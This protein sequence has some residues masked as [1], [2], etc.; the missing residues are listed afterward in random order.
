M[1]KIIN[2]ELVYFTGEKEC[3]IDFSGKE[4]ALSPDERIAFL[5]EYQKK[6][7]SW[8]D[9]AN[10]NQKAYSDDEVNSFLSAME[11][12]PETSIRREIRFDKMTAYDVYRE[13]LYNG[14]HLY[15]GASLSGNEITFPTVEKRGTPCAHVDI[16]PKE[17]LTVSLEVYT[18]SEYLSTQRKY[19]G[20]A[21]GGRVIELRVDTVNKAKI[22]I[23]NTGE[24]LALS[25]KMWAPTYTVIGTVEFGKWNKFTIKASDTF[26]VS[27]NDA[28]FV[29]GLASIAEGK[30]DNIFFDGGMWGRSEW[31]VRNITVDG[32]K[33]SYNENVNVNKVSK[34]E[35]REVS[36]PYA[37]G[38]KKMRN[39]ELYLTRKFNVDSFDYAELNIETLD[40]CGKVWINDKLVLDT[41]SFLAEKICI[42]DA[43]KCGENEIKIMVAPRAP[44]TYYFWHRHTDCYNGWFCGAV[45]IS[46]TNE[47]RICDLKVKTKSVNPV[48][49]IAEISSSFD[50]EV[51]LSAFEIFPNKGDS[52][53]LGS[54]KTSN[55]K[56]ILSF[57][58]DKLKLWNTKTP[59]LYAVKAELYEGDKAIDDFIVET[60]FRTICQKD[61]G[62]FLNDEQ[63]MLNGALLMQFLPP[64]DEVPVNHNCPTDFQIAMQM[65]S[66]KNMNGNF[67]RLHMLGYGSNDKRYARICDRLGIM[68]AWTTRLI[69]SLEEMAWDLKWRER[70][71]FVA[72]I[73]DVMNYPSIIMY[74]G[75]NEYHSKDLATVDRMYNDF[76]EAIVEVD[77]TRL[78]SPCSHLYYGGGIYEMG[79]CYFNDTGKLDQDGNPASAGPG[80]TQ[81]NV[82]RSAHT[83]DILCGYGS[84]WEV[85]RK[86]NWKWQDEML[87]SDK[88]AYLITEYA[89]TALPNPTTPEA[90]KT[91]YPQSYER[92]DELGAIDR[93][94]EDD[95]WR[96][97]QA[98]QALCAAQAVKHMRLKGVDGLAWCCLMSGAN[99]G[100]YMKPPIDFY[101]YKKLGFYSLRDGYRETYA[102]KRDINVSCGTESVIE[103]VIL[104]SGRAG[105]YDLKVSVLDSNDKLVCEKSYNNVKVFDFTDATLPSF[106][107]EWKSAGYYTVKYELIEK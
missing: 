79:C 65:V 63:I 46:L 67:L 14:V 105:E 8:Y 60:G 10:L 86:Q 12:E 44:E 47:K 4:N 52:I 104:N 95:E 82:V 39:R 29:E 66:L 59:V 3:K 32:E 88:T 58:S 74:E 20:D 100:S 91:P 87:S 28:P 94:F 6:A 98:L 1:G 48:S 9:D 31:K 54:V 49:A 23:C 25:G 40:P 16:E 11:A 22:K 33:L 93:R 96:E 43:L 97:S 15:M 53:S 17:S 41:K 18:P 72:Q 76:V 19:C 64:Y 62:V 92:D 42:N 68:L 55:G 35:E 69:D 75:S 83:Y 27:I 30:V 24:V 51:K 102:A 107:P 73:R 90:V 36:L 7:S 21:Q 38:G 85:M 70:E 2:R 45:S 61:G 89:I 34:S 56:A 37:I 78:L 50:G 71:E 84:S 99:N 103:P 81:K 13:P 57:E 26:A 5:N 106:K 101:G 77:D 80:W